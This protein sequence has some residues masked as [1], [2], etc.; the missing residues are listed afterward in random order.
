M[1]WNCV[2]IGAGAAGLYAASHLAI[3]QVLILEKKKKPALKLSVSGG[4]QCNLT[5]GGYA[6][7]LLNHYGPDKTFVKPALKAHDNQA[8]MAYFKSLG[9]ELVTRE[10]GKVFPKSLQSREIINALMHKITNELA[11]HIKYDE[12]VGQV[13]FKDDLYEIN[14]EKGTYLTK[15]LIV[16]TGGKSYPALGSEG[17]GYL[18]A[19]ALGIKVVPQF[20]GLAGVEIKKWPLQMLQGMSFQ[21]VNCLHLASGNTY[22]GDLL[23]THFGLSGPVIIN[24]S[25]DFRPGDS[26]SINFLGIS[27]EELTETFLTMAQESGHLPVRYFFNQLK[28]P[29]RF[30][31]WVY[32]TY[33]IDHHQRLGEV[34]KDLRTELVSVLTQYTIKIDKIQGYDQAMVTVG[35]VALEEIDRKKLCS[36]QYPGL[37]FIGEV[38]DVDGD[39]G[40]YNLQWAFSSGHA[41]SC[42]IAI[43][44]Q[45]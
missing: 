8:V 6:S 26:L 43:S 23:V 40:G 34:S 20:P 32:D 37:Y 9:V 19:E 4:G 17:D 14:T 38:L 10:D 36:K 5:H 27:R 2:I 30:K 13:A 7:A 28:I 44:S 45:R 39:T 29:D 18:F 41:A 1:I 35:G 21:M 3:D 33:K 24:N 11:H 15:H 25:R 42:A 16:A 31:Q 22:K 12:P